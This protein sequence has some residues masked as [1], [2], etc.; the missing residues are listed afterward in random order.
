M[1]AKRLTTLANFTG[2]TAAPGADTDFFVDGDRA[3]VSINIFDITGT[4]PTIGGTVVELISK[5][6]SLPYDGQTSN[7]TVG[8]TVTG[9]AFDGGLNATGVIMKDTDGGATGTLL[10]SN[11]KG[12]FKDN[13]ILRD[14]NGTQGVA[15]VNSA[16]GGVRVWAEGS[17]WATF[18]QGAVDIAQ[19]LLNPNLSS[20]DGDMTYVHPRYF[21]FKWVD[22]GTITNLDMSL[23]LLQQ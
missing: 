22:G 4:A 2:L 16:T 17:V 13:M 21:R 1:G 23:D 10:L 7:F 8:A 14:D 9:Y 18:A 6:W 20:G 12:K 15:V 19:Q 11:V 5:E 3:V